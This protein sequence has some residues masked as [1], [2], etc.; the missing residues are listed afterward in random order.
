MEKALIGCDKNVTLSAFIASVTPVL[1]TCVRNFCSQ[2]NFPSFSL[3]ALFGLLYGFILH[4][5]GY[6]WPLKTEFGIILGP[7]LTNLR[8]IFVHSM[9]I[10]AVL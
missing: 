2:R 6:F 7:N 5:I 3:L 1:L 4:F 8:P 9:Q 10:L